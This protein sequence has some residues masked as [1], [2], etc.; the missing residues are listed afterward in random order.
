M[1][2]IPALYIH[3]GKAASYIPG[4]YESIHYLDQSPY[5]L[6]ELLGKHNV[7]RI[8]LLDIDAARNPEHNNKAL[9]GSLANLA[10]PDL[11]VGGGINDMEYLKTLQY[12]GVDYFIL[13]SAVFHNFEFLEQICQAKDVKNDRILISL[14]M[15]DGRLTTSGW[16]ESVEGVTLGDVMRRCMEF[17][18][19]RF[20]VTDVSSDTPESGPDITFYTELI[21]AFPDAEIS[22]SGHIHTYEHLEA[23]K[24]IGIKEVVV[25]DKIYQE[26]ELMDKISAYNRR[27]EKEK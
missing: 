1:Q 6:I 21:E 12:A 16:T 19:N 15:L 18:L 14:D 25:G 10:V 2:I 7:Q 11:E 8:M 27:E 3:D 13:G 26:E 9:I 17:G 22:A 23:L 20:I 24:A 4:D 5:E